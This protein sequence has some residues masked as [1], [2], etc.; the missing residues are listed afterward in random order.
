MIFDKLLCTAAKLWKMHEIKEHIRFF[1]D[2]LMIPFLQRCAY[3]I[4]IILIQLSQFVTNEVCKRPQRSRRQVL[5]Y[6]K[7][8]IFSSY[9]P[10]TPL[11][12]L[13]KSPLTPK[14]G[15]KTPVRWVVLSR[16]AK[17]FMFS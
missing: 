9:D 10:L 15:I 2:Y 7:W 6:L 1:F 16:N 8:Q 12:P 14:N 11:S 13:P 5:Y 4:I 3:N 17:T